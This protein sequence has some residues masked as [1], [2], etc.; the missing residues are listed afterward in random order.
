MIRSRGCVA[1]AETAARAHPCPRRHA[2]ACAYS[3][4]RLRR[5]TSA[6]PDGLLWRALPQRRDV[7]ALGHAALDAV[8]LVRNG[9]PC[10]MP[11]WR[12]PGW[13]TPAGRAL[14]GQRSGWR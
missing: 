11:G 12:T 10:Q 7:A 13:R 14:E 9:R 3:R 6:D 1:A 2:N 8:D 4:G 5:G